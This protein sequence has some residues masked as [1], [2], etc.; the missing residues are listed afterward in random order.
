MWT[1]L[2]EPADRESVATLARLAR[3]LCP[4]LDI[5]PLSNPTTGCVRPPGAPHRSG[6]RSVVLRGDTTAL[7]TPTGTRAQVGALIEHLAQLVDDAEPSQT[8]DP[9]PAAPSR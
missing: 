9:P 5:A 8:P 7:T 1:A 6:G 3:H 2:A 4:T